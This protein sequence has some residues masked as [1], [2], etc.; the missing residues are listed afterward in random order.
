MVQLLNIQVSFSFA[1]FC[2]DSQDGGAV[3]YFDLVRKSL[4]NF[5][6]RIGISYI[7]FKFVGIHSSIHKVIHKTM[8]SANGVVLIETIAQIEGHI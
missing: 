2:N 5:L 7:P 6:K 4:K 8:A 1:I 3:C